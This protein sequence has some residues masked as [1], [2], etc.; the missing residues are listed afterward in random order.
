MGSTFTAAPDRAAGRDAGS[1]ALSLAEADDV[2]SERLG[3]MILMVRRLRHA[4]NRAHG[5]WSPLH[6]QVDE[7]EDAL[8][9]LEVDADHVRICFLPSE[10]HGR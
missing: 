10:G 6:P 2:L 1:R 4:L 9:D 3:D 5:P 8:I 7:L